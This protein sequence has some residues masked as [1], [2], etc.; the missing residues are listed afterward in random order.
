ML[1][2]TMNKQSKEKKDKDPVV[3]PTLGVTNNLG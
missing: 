3:V 1:E 2:Q